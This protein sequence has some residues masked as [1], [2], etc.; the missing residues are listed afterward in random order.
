VNL[1]HDAS[2]SFQLGYQALEA[3]RFEE[4]VKHYRVVVATSPRNAAAWYNL[5][6]A[7]EDL[8]RWDEALTAYRRSWEVDPLDTRHRAAYLGTC[9]RRGVEAAQAGRYAEAARYLEAATKVDA[10]DP[11]TWFVLFRVYTALGREAEAVAARERM[12]SLKPSSP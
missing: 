10:D 2:G 8:K 12:L 3:G 11:A 1:A 7:Y 6:I 5:G 9:V 4:A